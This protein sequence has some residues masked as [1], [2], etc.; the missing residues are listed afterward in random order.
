[1]TDL[2]F[3]L[4]GSTLIVGPSGIGKTTLTARA[5]E[6]W[7]DRHGADGIVVFDFG[8]ELERSGRTIGS[9]LD[10]FTTVPD[11]VWVGRFDAHGPR[12]EGTTRDDVLALARENAERANRLLRTA[13]AEPRAVFIND[14]T[15]AVHHE[16]GDLEA[17]L[18]Y[19]SEAACVVMNAFDGDD[20]GTTDPISR[21]ERTVL[22]R[23]EAWAD[24][25]VEPD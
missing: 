21:R 22:E 10:Q 12:S 5:L 2:P 24:R 1:M 3:P 18:E 23:L 20:F 9:R 6:M 15:I 11:P 4:V 8:P 16:A 7:V 14:A 13:P 17:L 25:V 19:S